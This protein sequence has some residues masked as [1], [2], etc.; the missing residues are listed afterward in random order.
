MAPASLSQ[1][2]PPPYLLPADPTAPTVASSSPFLNSC[3]HPL[4]S[5]L[6]ASFSPWHTVCVR[7]C[8]CVHVRV[9]VCVWLARAVGL[10]KGKPLSPSPPRTYTLSAKKLRSPSV[11][12]GTCCLHTCLASPGQARGG[13]SGPCRPPPQTATVTNRVSDTGAEAPSPAHSGQTGFGQRD[14]Q[15]MTPVASE[16]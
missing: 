11:S 14:T 9:R 6:L 5:A 3:P 10:R 8:M 16:V 13:G 7:A 2:S 1:L 15:N 4:I 12:Q